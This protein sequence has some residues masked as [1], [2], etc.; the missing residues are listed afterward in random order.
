MN[1]HLETLKKLF[2]VCPVSTILEF[3]TGAFSTPLFSDYADIVVTIEQQDLNWVDIAKKE[4]E[5]N[6]KKNVLFYYVP[7]T[8]DRAN[9]KEFL[10]FNRFDFVFIDGIDRYT[11]LDLSLDVSNLI[12]M[13]DSQSW[14]Q[15]NKI[16]INRQKD[17]WYGWSNGGNPATSIIAKDK[18][19]LIKLD[20]SMKQGVFIG[21]TK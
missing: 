4:I 12:A 6:G 1:S 13:H 21:E 19:I 9:L 14:W 5:K 2:N 11:C 16:P 15:E 3:G 18:N 20:E 8:E 17:E 7:Q 10:K